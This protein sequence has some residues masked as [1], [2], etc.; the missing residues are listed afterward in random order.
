MLYVVNIFLQRIK[1]KQ[2]PPKVDNNPFTSWKAGGPSL[3]AKDRSFQLSQ[4]ASKNQFK[5]TPAPLNIDFK[6]KD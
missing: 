3:L 2:T 1:M 6:R 5:F 4:K